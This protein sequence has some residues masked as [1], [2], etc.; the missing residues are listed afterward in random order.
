MRTS[1]IP[2]ELYHYT[3][4]DIMTKLLSNI[5]SIEIGEPPNCHGEPYITFWASSVF[6][7][8][9]HKEYSLHDDFLNS[10]N[11]IAKLNA[12]SVLGHPFLICFSEKKDFIPMWNMYGNRGTGVC[13][14]FDGEL[15]NRNIP[16]KKSFQENILDKCHY[17]TPK[18][19]KKPKKIRNKDLLQQERV[20][21]SSM[22]ACAFDKPKCFSYEK[23]WRLMVWKNFEMKFRMSGN[24]TIPYTEVEI[25]AECIQRIILGP[26]LTMD[27]R[28]KA[29]LSIELLKQNSPYPRVRDL[30]ITDSQTSLKL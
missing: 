27:E 13:L 17:T 7:L 15:L 20:L 22:K 25:P 18:N 28:E 26:C 9:D 29:K 23:E 14:K 12:K 30:E 16:Q 24:Y 4:L 5:K 2:T 21:I 19:E 6:Y 11:P 1:K 10:F 3:S 8:N